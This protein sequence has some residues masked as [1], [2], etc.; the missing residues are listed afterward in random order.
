[1]Q[2]GQTFGLQVLLQVQSWPFRYKSKIRSENCEKY[3]NY[4]N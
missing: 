4:N 1:M 3:N 2:D